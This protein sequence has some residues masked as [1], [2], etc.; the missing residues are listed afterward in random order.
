MSCTRVTPGMPPDATLYQCSRLSIPVPGACLLGVR[1]CGVVGPSVTRRWR[2][3]AG[4]PA[5]PCQQRLLRCER[6]AALCAGLQPSQ[7][8]ALFFTRGRSWLTSF[9]SRLAAARC[10]Y[11]LTLFR[12]PATTSMPHRTAPKQPPCSRARLLQDP[13]CNT[14]GAIKARDATC[15]KCFQPS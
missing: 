14:G 6:L 11:V 3:R 5:A 13:R 2:W 12:A 10:A 15:H 7:A 1:E 4:R 8:K 9:S